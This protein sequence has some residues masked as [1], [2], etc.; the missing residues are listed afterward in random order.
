MERKNE[1]KKKEVETLHF[2]FIPSN[3]QSI[4]HQNLVIR[5]IMIT[6]SATAS[7]HEQK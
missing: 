3:F 1:N 7:E 5:T 2:R 6:L 4:F